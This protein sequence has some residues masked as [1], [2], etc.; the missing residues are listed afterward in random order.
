MMKTEWTFP[1]DL[2]LLDRAVMFAVMKHSGQR[3]KGSDIPYITHVVE[4]MEIVSRMTE[5]EELR[6]AAV[7]HD[8]LEDT[9]TG[10]EELIRLFGQRVADLV[11]A[12]SE[13]KRPDQPEAETW[14]TR[15]QETIRHLS[16]ASTEV[17]MLALGDK[18]S[19]IRAMHRDFQ[20]LGEK[21]WERFNQKDPVMHGMYY[22]LLANIFGEDEMLSGTPAYHEYIKLCIDLFGSEDET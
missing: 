7:L 8:T 5:D 18:L 3:R 1:E 21:L 19:N 13:N 12:E 2:P 4:A 14:L 17:R 20:V 6:A 16:R 22:G 15:K 9:D 11:A 10:K